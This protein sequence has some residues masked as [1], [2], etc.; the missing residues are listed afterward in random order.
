YT[1]YQITAPA[2]QRLPGGGG[3]VVS[4]LF[5]VNPAFSGQINTLITDSSKYGNVS[6]YFNGVDISL[7]VRTA[8]GLTIQG[9]TSTGQN[10][11]DACEARA[12]RAGCSLV[13]TGTLAR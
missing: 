4:G 6:Q 1:A 7:N 5:D 9:G 2:D 12:E 11:A 10:V 13:S 8:A 3:Y